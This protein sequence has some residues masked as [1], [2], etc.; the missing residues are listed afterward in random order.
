MKANPSGFT[1]LELLIAMVVSGMIVTGAVVVFT[2]MARSHNTDV[3]LKTMQQNLRATMNYLEHYIRMA[4]Y[5][6]SNQAGAG[7]VLIDTDH[8]S[9]TMDIGKKSGDEIIG[10]PNGVIDDHWDE[11]VEFL[12]VD[13]EIKRANAGGQ[14]RLLATDIEALNFV[15]LDNEGKETAN[16]VDV[17]SVQIAIV[18]RYGKEA[19]F[20]N[21]FID[22]TKYT[23]QQGDVILPAPNDRIRRMMLTSDISCRNMKW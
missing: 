22:K 18:A 13:N 11:K 1:L 16:P 19:G 15:Y 23:N 12:L 9:F 4:G 10:S 21:T 17:Q 14:D 6:P 8:I 20:T 5:D 7:F 2:T 3:R